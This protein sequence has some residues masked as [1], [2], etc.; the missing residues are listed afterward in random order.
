[1]PRTLN[2]EKYI[3]RRNEILDAALK[4]VYTKGYEHMTIQD[5]LDALQI[6]KGAFYHYFASK[7]DVL[8]AMVERMIVEQVTPLLRPIVDDPD[9]PALEKF[10]RFYQ[11]AGRWK[12]SQKTFMLELLQVWM[13]DENAIVRQKLMTSSIKSV[14]PM[15]TEIVRQGVEEGV[16]TSPYPDQVSN[17]IIYIMEGLSEKLTELLVSVK[18]QHT[19]G[20][21]DGEINLFIGAMNDAIERVLGAPKGSLKLI[22]PQLMKVWFE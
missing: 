2:E 20:D 5:I 14:A 22:D 17:V 12:I 11:V 13:G 19:E 9:L 10:H 7:A 18:I 3:E 4:L 8:E 6:S 16:F 1:M 21:V 15:L